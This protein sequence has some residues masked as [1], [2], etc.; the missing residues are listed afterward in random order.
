M[1]RTKR[2]P[3]ASWSAA[4]C[5][6]STAGPRVNALTTPVPSRALSVQVAATA[7]GVKASWPAVSSDHTSV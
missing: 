2:P 7:S 3:L 4:Q 5:C 1:P 6:A